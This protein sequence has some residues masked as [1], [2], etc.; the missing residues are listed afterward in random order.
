MYREKTNSWHLPK[1]TQE[2]A[3]TREETA[4]QEVFE[5]TGYRIEI[6]KYIG[7]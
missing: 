7:Y 3:E 2:N 1:R 4:L 6:Q 5:E